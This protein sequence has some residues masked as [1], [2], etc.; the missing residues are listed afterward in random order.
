MRIF[1]NDPRTISLG[2]EY[3]SI[4]WLSYLPLAVSNVCIF[5]LR[6]IGEN[7]MSMLVSLAAMGV[8]ALCN[9][10]LIFGRLGMPALGVRGA[11]LGTLIARTVEMLFYLRMLLA[12]AP[13]SRWTSEPPSACRAR[14]CVHLPLRPCR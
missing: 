5:S 11:A 1:V 6:S 9:Y 12:G 14:W 7:R 3:L 13:C 2:M 10:A 4:I 8:N